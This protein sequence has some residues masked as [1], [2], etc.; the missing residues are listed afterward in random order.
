MK[1]D[2]VNLDV[3]VLPIPFPYAVDLVLGTSSKFRQRVVDLLGW[4]YTQM[5]PDIDGMVLN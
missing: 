4:K 5:S 1:K 3:Q 2:A